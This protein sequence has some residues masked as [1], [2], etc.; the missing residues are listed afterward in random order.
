L[1][2]LDIS[3]NLITDTGCEHLGQLLQTDKQVKKI[4]MKNNKGI[5]SAGLKLIS[6]SIRKNTHI[7][8]IDLSDCSI[9][10][11]S[12]FEVILDDISQNCSLTTVKLEN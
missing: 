10:L 8:Y 7:D 11:E 5:T 2:E 4:V 3:N 1:E 12:K 9:Q 6:K